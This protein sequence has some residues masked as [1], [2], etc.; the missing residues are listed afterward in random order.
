MKIIK[1]I[2]YL[3]KLKLAFQRSNTVCLLGPRQCGKTTLARSF[4]LST[5]KHYFDLENPRHVS[6]LSE[7]MIA[8]ESLDGLIVIDEVQRKP[9]IFEIIRVLVDRPDNSAKF[10]LLGSASFSLIHGISETLAGRTAFVDISGFNILEIEKGYIDELWVRGGF[11]LSYLADSEFNSKAWREDFIRTFL[12]RDIPQI[13]FSI[14]SVTMRR[15][16][17]MIAHYHGN[18]W[19]AAEFARSLGSAEAT[20]RK[21]LDILTGSFVVRQL[22]PWFE[23]IKKR[24]LKAPK[25]YI[26]DSGI[27]H[28]LLSIDDKKSLLGH[29]KL[30]ASWEGF[31]IE[32]ILSLTDNNRDVYFWGTHAGCELDILMFRN[33][34]RIGFEVKYSDAPIIS[35]SMRIALSDLNLEELFVVYPG[36]EKYKLDKKITVIPLND[37]QLKQY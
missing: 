18:N 20:A 19:N 8:L 11:P 37:I 26:R 28:S 27:L 15:F 7:P 2:Q 24:Q 23:N 6:M 12:E 22:P 30:G 32:Q 16:W 29:P 10:L 9:K 34:K 14:P 36:Q 21:Y 25:I 3:E 31:V 17:T 35:K 33:G 1:R 13:G 4:E 5:E